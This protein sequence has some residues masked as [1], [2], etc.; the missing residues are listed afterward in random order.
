[1]SEAWRLFVALEL[2]EEIRSHLRALQEDLKRRTPGRAVRWV[3]PA[4]IH[5]TLH[6]LGDV[7]RGRVEALDGALG[8]A[9][10][11]RAPFELA[12]G[13]LSCFPNARRPRVVWV[14]LGGQLAPLG[15]LHAAVERELGALGFEPED[16]AFH[17]HLTLGRVR[18]EAARPAVEELARVLQGAAAE[19]SP[20]FRVADVILFRSELRPSGAVYSALHHAPL[21]AP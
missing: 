1:M 10:R 13:G 18:Q 16:R 21:A 2:P 9:A 14:G 12:T 3:D 6:F 5:L 8:A 15:A 7:E 11:G 19:P 17:P 20:P 4:G